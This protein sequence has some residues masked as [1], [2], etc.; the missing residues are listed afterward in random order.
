MGTKVLPHAILKE[1]DEFSAVIMRQQLVDKVLAN[2][3]GIP[4]E[5]A[6]R[7]G[8]TIAILA[9]QFWG[10][11]PGAALKVLGKVDNVESLVTKY[12]DATK[13]FARCPPDWSEPLVMVSFPKT[14]FTPPA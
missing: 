5:D 14:A 13:L 8:E 2:A 9:L 12:P 3:S 1:E 11:D 10:L 7:G 4:G 6:M